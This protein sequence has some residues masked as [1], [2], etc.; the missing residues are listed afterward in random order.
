MRV[1][2]KLWGA[3]RPGEDGL[4]SAVDRSDLAKLFAPSLPFSFLSS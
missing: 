1:H 2:A 3:M 4:R